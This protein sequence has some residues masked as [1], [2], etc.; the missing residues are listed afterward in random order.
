M[1]GGE[2]FWLV[3]TPAQFFGLF[4]GGPGGGQQRLWGLQYCAVI[5]GKKLCEY[6]IIYIYALF[7]TLKI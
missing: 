3:G 6:L 1:G 2:Q 5:R 7:N 4:G